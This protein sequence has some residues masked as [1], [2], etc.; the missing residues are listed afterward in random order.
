MTT[1]YFISTV[2]YEKVMENGMVKTVNEQYL[3][4]ALSFTEAEARTIEELTPFISGEF[5]IPQIVK[6]RIAELFLSNDVAADR[7]YKVKVA[8]VTLDEKSGT[9]KKT[10]THMLVQAKDFNDAYHSFLQ[11][12]K[13]TMAD[14]EV[15]SIVETPII[16]YFPAEHE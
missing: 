7:Y 4:D 15:Q 10:A 12:M 5:S 13:G 11:G 8:F 1:R 2:R 3:L 14:F 6:P 9:E 16:D